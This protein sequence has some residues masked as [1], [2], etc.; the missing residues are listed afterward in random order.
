LNV[1]IHVFITGD[2]TL[3][4]TVVGKEGEQIKAFLLDELERMG[5]RRAKREVK[6]LCEIVAKALLLFDGFLSLLRTDHKD[7]TPQPSRRPKSTQ[8]KPWQYGR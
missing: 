6:K 4:A 7:L 2:L 8:Q 1:P 3:Y 5:D